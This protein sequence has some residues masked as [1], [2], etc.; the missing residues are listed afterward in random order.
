MLESETCLVTESETRSWP[1]RKLFCTE[2]ETFL[3]TESETIGLPSR[4]LG[5]LPGGRKVEG[6][7]RVPS[8]RPHLGKV[9]SVGSVLALFSFPDHAWIHVWMHAW[10]HA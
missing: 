4:K 9:D 3:G 5:F 10:I 8:R 6:S 1:S 2:S 7:S